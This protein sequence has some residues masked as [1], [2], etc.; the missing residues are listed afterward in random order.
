MLKNYESTLRFRS[1]FGNFVPC[2]LMIQSSF[3]R[4]QLLDLAATHRSAFVLK[5]ENK[6]SRDQPLGPYPANP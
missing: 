4:G 1:L 5:E 2:T 3:H 6:G